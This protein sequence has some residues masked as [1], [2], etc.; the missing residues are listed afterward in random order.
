MGKKTPTNYILL[1]I[2][3]LSF[4]IPI[5]GMCVY[6]RENVLLVLGLALIVFLT[7]SVYALI[8]KTDF[9]MFGGGLTV[10]LVVIIALSLLALFLAS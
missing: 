3:V 2:F 8:T 5:M 7:L 9:T 10:A 4:A 6:F 1:T